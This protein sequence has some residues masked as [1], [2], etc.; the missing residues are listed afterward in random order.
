VKDESWVALKD[1]F[2]LDIVLSTLRASQFET[3]TKSTPYLSGCR[4]NC[5]IDLMSM[6]QSSLVLASYY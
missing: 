1:H 2:I 4:Q 3:S 6:G 5:R